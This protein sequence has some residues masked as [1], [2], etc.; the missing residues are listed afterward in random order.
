[1]SLVLYSYWRSSAAW[2]VRIALALKGVVHEVR[3][4]NLVKGAQEGEEYGAV[5]PAHLV[6]ALVLPGGEVLTQSLAI[7]DWLE[8]EHPTPRLVPADSLARARVL[9]A[10]HTVAMDIHPVNNLRILGALG[11]RFGADQAAKVAWMQEWM[12]KGF[13]VLEGMAR[14]GPYF[15][16]PQVTL[17][18]LCLVPQVYNARRWG[19]DMARWPGLQAVEAAC[20][21][22]PA[23]ADTA[24]ERQAD[25]G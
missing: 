11:A 15:L 4:V 8:A 9:A 7:I 12:V 17:A 10:A 21:A 16:G 14:P 20:L 6:P 24:P 5:N 22:L 19:L 18:D 13:D 3:A 25:A 2:R 1:M 23:F